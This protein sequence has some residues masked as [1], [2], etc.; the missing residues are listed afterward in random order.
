[1]HGL[2][3]ISFQIPTGHLSCKRVAL[4]RSCLLPSIGVPAPSTASQLTAVAPAA[5]TFCA[6]ASTSCTLARPAFAFWAVNQAALV[7][8]PSYGAAYCHAAGL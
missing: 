6:A 3:P 8:A 1:M 5:S 2:S 7:N 4:S